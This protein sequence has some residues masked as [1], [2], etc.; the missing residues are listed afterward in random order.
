MED[1]IIAKMKAAVVIVSV[2]STIGSGLSVTHAQETALDQVKITE[3]PTAKK[4][5]GGWRSPSRS[6]HLTM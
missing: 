6:P 5:P 2:L 4:A 1:T 3:G